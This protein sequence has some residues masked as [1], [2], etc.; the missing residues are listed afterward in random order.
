M[1]NS[2]FSFL[3]QIN[4]VRS[5]EEKS[6]EERHEI[7]CQLADQKIRELKNQCYELV[8]QIARNDRWLLGLL[9]KSI[10]RA[11]AQGFRPVNEKKQVGLIPLVV[12]CD[13][14]QGVPR[15][16]GLNEILKQLPSNRTISCLTDYALTW[17]EVT[18]PDFMISLFDKM[19]SCYISGI[20]V[21]PE[22]IQNY[23]EEP[24]S[25]VLNE[26]EYDSGRCCHIRFL[27][28][29]ILPDEKPWFED[30]FSKKQWQNHVFQL[31]KDTQPESIWVYPQPPNDYVTA[32]ATA[33]S[34]GQLLPSLTSMMN[35]VKTQNFPNYE[36]FQLIIAPLGNQKRGIVSHYHYLVVDPSNNSLMAVNLIQPLIFSE[37]AYWEDMCKKIKNIALENLSIPVKTAPIVQ[38]LATTLKTGP[39]R[40]IFTFGRVVLFEESF[41]EGLPLLSYNDEN[42]E[43][44]KYWDYETKCQETDVDL[45]KEAFCSAFEIDKNT[46]TAFCSFWL[47][48]TLWRNTCVVVIQNAKT[49]K[50]IELLYPL[51]DEIL[52]AVAELLTV[53]LGRSWVKYHHFDEDQ[54]NFI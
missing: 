17:E 5:D 43:F 40:I 20:S 12:M 8:Q 35:W 39:R 46:I 44:A 31:I 54:N 4:S 24:V 47:D 32:L 36:N 2:N 27:P 48:S 3:N 51:D 37:R 41:P 1:G 19:E 45:V 7:C 14:D 10:E 11:F 21:E 42:S 15:K 26:F 50:G 25:S 13:S 52:K 30:F 28:A 38:D 6:L 9:A 29:F 53:I 22:L 23:G 33:E 16:L 34:I 18:D 49:T